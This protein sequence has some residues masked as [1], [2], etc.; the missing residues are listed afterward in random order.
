LAGVVLAAFILCALHGQTS[1][2]ITQTNSSVQV[3]YV[4]TTQMDEVRMELASSDPNRQAAA[5]EQMARLGADAAPAAIELVLAAGNEDENIREQATAALEG[6]GAPPTTLFPKLASLLSDNNADVAYWAAT[7]LG[8][9][10]AEA[11]EA[12]AA[13]STCVAGHPEESARERAAWALGEIGPSAVDARAQLE[14][15][16]ESGGPRLSRMARRALDRIE[17]R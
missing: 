14:K 3:E 15:A 1:P 6:L 2:R 5:A 7:L 11:G 17:K 9:A 4:M 16:A 8:R 13:L 10:G 12:T